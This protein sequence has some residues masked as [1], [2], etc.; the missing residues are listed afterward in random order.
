M[1]LITKIIFLQLAFVSTAFSADLINDDFENSLSGQIWNYLTEGAS[2]TA[3]VGGRTI[4]IDVTRLGVEDHGKMVE[5]VED[6][7]F[8]IYNTKASYFGNSNLGYGLLFNLAT[9]HLKDQEL[10]NSEVVN[11][12][13]EVDGY[14]AYTVP[15]IFYNFGDRHRGHY[16]RTGIGLGIGLAEF[17]GNV[18][19]TES[20]L[21]SDRVDISN[22]ASNLFAAFGVF[23]DYQWENFTLRIATAGPSLM[24]NGYNMNISDTS[25]MFGVTYYLGD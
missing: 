15:T 9:F 20:L 10:I 16:L 14:F 2:V 3:G 19:L 18:V 24:Y 12:G 1:S 21:P 23:I 13:T 6:A 25:V 11:L 5:K 22:G 17:N 4:A 8:L 7:L